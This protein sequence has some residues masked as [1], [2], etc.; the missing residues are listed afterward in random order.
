MTKK[1]LQNEDVRKTIWKGNWRF[2]TNTTVI[3]S[4]EPFSRAREVSAM[5]ILQ[6]S[7]IHSEEVGSKI[8]RLIKLTRNVL[9]RSCG[10]KIRF[11]ETFIDEASNFFI[12]HYVPGSNIEERIPPKKI[13]ELYQMP[14]H[15]NT[16]N[17]VSWVTGTVKI[18]G[19]TDTKLSPKVSL[20]LYFRSP[21]P[22]ETERPFPWIRPL[23]TVPP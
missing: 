14:S 1:H 8:I 15:A 5:Q 7:S 4:V 21:N 16:A 6:I 23:E 22:R 9:G 3:L 19:T 10:W 2:P 17:F 18:S 13:A 12:A 20:S 11:G